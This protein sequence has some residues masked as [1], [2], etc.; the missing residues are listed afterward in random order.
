[1]NSVQVSASLDS[2]SSSSDSHPSPVHLP[3]SQCGPEQLTLRQLGPVHSPVP[4]LQSGPI[5]PRET[6]SGPVQRPLPFQSPPLQ[7]W[8]SQS[9]PSHSPE[10]GQSAPMHAVG[11]QSDPR[12]VWDDLSQS[13]P[14][15]PFLTHRSPS[16]F[17]PLQSGPLH[18]LCDGGV[19]SAGSFQLLLA[20]GSL[21]SS[22]HGVSQKDLHLLP[23]F[24]VQVGAGGPP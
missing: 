17:L 10:S 4:G 8:V 11:S 15:Q 5:Q 1:M 6:Q 3:S 18:G 7:P 9:S 12:Q 16:H 23:Q 22:K 2:Q 24:E 13:G 21:Q 19:G 14:V 20:T